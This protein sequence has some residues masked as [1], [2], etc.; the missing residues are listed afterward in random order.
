MSNNTC[1]F[2]L[3]A[4]VNVGLSVGLGKLDDRPEDGDE[5]SAG[6]SSS[7]DALSPRS[8]MGVEFVGVLANVGT[9]PG[10]DLGRKVALQLRSCMIQQPRKATCH[11]TNRNMSASTK[12]MEITVLRRTSMSLGFLLSVRQLGDR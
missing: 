1:V 6:V 12:T 2:W 5:R 11:G 10:Y 7:S 9:E 3:Y 4:F 8:R